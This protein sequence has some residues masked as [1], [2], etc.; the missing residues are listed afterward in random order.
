MGIIPF[1]HFLIEKMHHTEM[2]TDLVKLSRIIAME[3]FKNKTAAKI[4]FAARKRNQRFTEQLFTLMNQKELI[5]IK[6]PR[7]SAQALGYMLAGISQDYYYYSHCKDADTVVIMEKQKSMVT[8]F[9]NTFVKE[10]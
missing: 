2:K 3:Q 9:F 8:W 6:D 10:K 4:A 7:V 1:F 5:Q